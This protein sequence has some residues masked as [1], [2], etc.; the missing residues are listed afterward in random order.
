MEVTYHLQ[1]IPFAWDLQKARTNQVKHG[2]H[3]E[4]ACEVFFDPFF[5]VVDASRKGDERN[6]I[7]GEDGSGR[8]LFVVH[9]QPVGD[10]LRLISARKSTRYERKTYENQ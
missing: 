10:V 4:R 3:F 2:V 8:L 5:C 1:G 7:I 9:V 6:A